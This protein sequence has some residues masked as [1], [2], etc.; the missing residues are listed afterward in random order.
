MHAAV[1]RYILLKAKSLH[2][3]ADHWQQVVH[4]AEAQYSLIKFGATQLG[5]LL[6]RLTDRKLHL[7]SPDQDC[8]PV[9]SPQARHL[10]PAQPVGQQSE[11]TCP[12]P[13]G[14]CYNQQ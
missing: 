6:A 10:G 3:D 7:I 11:T 8:N 9:H 14:L 2:L 4:T 5:L 12:V 13:Q 1:A